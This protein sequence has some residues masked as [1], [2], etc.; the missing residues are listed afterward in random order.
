MVKILA[1]K[2]RD[3]GSIPTVS[4]SFKA[5]VH[6]LTE[7]IFAACLKLGLGG[8]YRYSYG[9]SRNL[10]SYKMHLNLDKHL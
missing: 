9:R 5:T 8:V 3:S 10:H 4:M 6:S 7:Q 1:V 2:Q